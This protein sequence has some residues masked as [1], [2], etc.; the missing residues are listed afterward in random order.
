MSIYFWRENERPYGC[1]SQWYI[2]S[3]TDGESTFNCCE[4][5]MMFIKA[6]LFND[7]DI[8]DKIMNEK[9]PKNQKMLGRKVKN[10]NH[11]KWNFYKESIVYMAN[12]YK[13]TQNKELKKILLSTKYNIYEASPYDKIWGIGITKR[14]AENGFKHNGQN[15]LGIALMN[16]RNDLIK[17][18]K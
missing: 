13:F 9:L 12:Y 18:Q 8:A 11:D 2:S 1:F 17:E 5:Y 7:Y 3:F 4:Q 6:I 14:Q 15:L 10:F 16:V